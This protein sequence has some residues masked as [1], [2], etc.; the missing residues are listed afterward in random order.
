MANTEANYDDAERTDEIDGQRFD[1]DE[2][3]ERQF[4]LLHYGS[5]ASWVDDLTEWGLL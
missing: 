4:L 5:A 3:V 2:S 1:E